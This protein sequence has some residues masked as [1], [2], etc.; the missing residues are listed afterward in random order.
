MIFAHSAGLSGILIIYDKI[1]YS[2]ERNPNI[3]EKYALRLGEL[4]TDRAN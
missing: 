2:P 3:L 4:F 1:D